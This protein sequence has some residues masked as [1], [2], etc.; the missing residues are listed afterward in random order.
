M[1]FPFWRTKLPPVVIRITP[2]K[3][4]VTYVPVG[5]CR[6]HY[7]TDAKVRHLLEGVYSDFYLV[8]TWP[9]C[10]V[11]GTNLMRP[12]ADAGV[13]IFMW[14]YLTDQPSSFWR[15]CDLMISY[16]QNL[17]SPSKL[18]V[19]HELPIDGPF[20]VGDVSGVEDDELFGP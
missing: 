12:L 3:R 20:V 18:H 16:L 4:R 7:D 6:T 5:A 14:S 17:K 19:E 8:Y 15:D 2:G 10:E 13:N 11:L 1:T 9:M